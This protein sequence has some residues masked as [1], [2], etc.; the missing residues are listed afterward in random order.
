MPNKNLLII[1]GVALLILAGA[2]VYRSSTEE[3][4]EFTPLAEEQNGQVEEIDSSLETEEDDDGGVVASYQKIENVFLDLLEKIL[5][6]EEDVIEKT[7][8][9]VL[10][11]EKRIDSVGKEIEK[12]EIDSEKINNE[13]N[14]I[15]E[16]I[17]EI[18]K[19]IL[20]LKEEQEKENDSQEN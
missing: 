11:L 14:L 19:K 13:L 7:Q 15:E 20:E 6:M 16:R 4:E 12:E 3:G 5:S 8:D 18:T 2:I 17:E 9:D 10:D 1:F